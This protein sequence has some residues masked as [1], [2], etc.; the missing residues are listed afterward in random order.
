MTL[1]IKICLVVPS[2][3][4]GGME[5][6]MSEVANYLAKDSNFEVHLIL[7]SSEIFFSISPDVIIHKPNHE[8]SNKIKLIY[9]SGNYIRKILKDIQPYSVLSFGSMYNSFVLLFTLGL[10]LKIYVSDRSNSYRSTELTLKKDSV[11]RHDGILHYFL[12]K[13][14]YKRAAG[15]L[16][17]TQKAKKIEYNFSKHENIILFPNP[18][19][20]IEDQLQCKENWIINVGRFVRTKNQLQLIEIFSEIYFGKW[21][22]VFAGD[23]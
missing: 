22:L 9:Q 13:I 5:R 6:V 21:K 23:G 7:L 12:K 4:A 15:I 14:L 11:K 16:V 10:D 17:Q 20:E 1:P 3:K 18:I 8:T 19:R 2:L